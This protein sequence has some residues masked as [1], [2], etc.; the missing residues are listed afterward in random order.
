MDIYEGDDF[1]RPS[2]TRRG[3]TA[4]KKSVRRTVRMPTVRA[5]PPS[6]PK[7]FIPWIAYTCGLSAYTVRA[8]A[9]GHSLPCKGRVS[10][11][12]GPYGTEEEDKR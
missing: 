4:C 9:D 5:C 11:L 2:R 7:L 12:S 3:R 6:A 8:T 10:A 1:M